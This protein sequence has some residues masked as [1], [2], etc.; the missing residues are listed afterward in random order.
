[1]TEDHD[2]ETGE[3]VPHQEPQAPAIAPPPPGFPPSPFSGPHD[4]IDKALAAVTREAAPI[5]KGGTNTFQNYKYPRIEDYTEVL[6]D[7]IGKHELA[8]YETAI[9]RNEISQMVY[10]DYHFYISTE[11]QTAGPF[12]V[13]GQARSRDSKGNFDPAALPKC[14]TSA[15]KQFYTARFHLKTSDDPDRDAPARAS[16]ART[17][18]Q[19]PKE[20]PLQAGINIGRPQTLPLGDMGWEDW[21]RNFLQ[22]IRTCAS[23]DTVEK[24]LGANTDILEMIRKDNE[25]HH[26]FVMRQYHKRIRELQPSE[27]VQ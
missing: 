12:K 17:P 3:I 23:L 19:S 13:T 4:K 24:W 1:M 15:R 18:I 5:F 21:S 27:P 2:H 22:I 25:P 9:G 11:G 8:I 7:L 6:A 26:Q 14:L 10:V 20:Q 16:N